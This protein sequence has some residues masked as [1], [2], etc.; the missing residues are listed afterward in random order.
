MQPHE[1]LY[2]LYSYLSNYIIITTQTPFMQHK[3]SYNEKNLRRRAVAPNAFTMHIHNFR[4]CNGDAM[5]GGHYGARP[6]YAQA[7]CCM[8]TIRFVFLL[9][10]F[11][12]TDNIGIGAKL[13]R[14]SV[15]QQN[16]V[17]C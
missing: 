15:C 1:V 7:K 2:I 12:K 6:N 16:E 17:R 8:N 4:N 10:L 9:F 5:L 13:A 11:G 14:R 3:Y